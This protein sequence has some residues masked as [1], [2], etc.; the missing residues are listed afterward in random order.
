MAKRLSDTAAIAGAPSVGD[1]GCKSINISVEKIENGYVTRTSSYGTG[2]DD[3]K[4]KEVYSA[5]AP[6]IAMPSEPRPRSVGSL[7]SAI[8]SLK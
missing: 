3:Y 1:D 2:M 4:S 6:K 7:S 5:A 8:K